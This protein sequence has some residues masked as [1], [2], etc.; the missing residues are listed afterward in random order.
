M[1]KREWSETS[2]KLLRSSGQTF[3]GLSEI[4]RRNNEAVSKRPPAVIAS[5]FQTGLNLIRD[6]ERRGIR[7]IGI[8][9]NPKNPGFRSRYGRSYLCPN[10]DLEP[11]KWVDFMV[12]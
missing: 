7:A 4:V 9:S 5:V 2:A 3:P 8:D 10:P 12:S 11:E 1:L 6:L